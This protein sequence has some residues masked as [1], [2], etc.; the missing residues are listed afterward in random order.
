MFVDFDL[1]Q[2]TAG[3]IG[4]I[5]QVR[6]QRITCVRCQALHSL[7]PHSTHP[8][9]VLRLVTLTLTM[10]LLPPPVT[11]RPPLAAPRATHRNCHSPPLHARP[12]QFITNE[13]LH[14]G[15]RE[16]GTAIFE[17]LLNIAR[18]GILLR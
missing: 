13:Y 2:E 3:R 18:G 5:R 17:K 10:L 12:L 8:C 1:A 4:G 16:A 7:P 14:C 15:I 11:R 6:A 9:S